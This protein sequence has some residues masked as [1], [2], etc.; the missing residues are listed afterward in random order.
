MQEGYVLARSGDSTGAHRV[1]REL[2][3]EHLSAQQ[4]LIYAA[5]GELDSMYVLFERAIDARD[6]DALWFLNALPALRPMRHEPRY[7]ALLERM[8]LPEELR[9]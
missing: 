1:L 3:R 6:T 4:A 8:G 7:Q 2:S 9:R 5:L